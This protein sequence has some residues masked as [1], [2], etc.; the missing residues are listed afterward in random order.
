MHTH[1]SGTG[2]HDLLICENFMNKKTK[3]KTKQNKKRRFI[4]SVQMKDEHPISLP[5]SDLHESRKSVNLNSPSYVY[6]VSTF[7]KVILSVSLRKDL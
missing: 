1:E 3:N 5:F 6:N 4:I 7:T 2:G